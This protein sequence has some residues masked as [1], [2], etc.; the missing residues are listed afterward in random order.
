MVAQP[1]WWEDGKGG[2]D[3]TKQTVADDTGSMA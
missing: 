3:A 2:S 1:S